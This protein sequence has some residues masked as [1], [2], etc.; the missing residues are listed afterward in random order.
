MPYFEVS[1]VSQK[2]GKPIKPKIVEAMDDARA[3]V[4][5][6]ASGM[7]V[8]SI[9]RLPDDEP[10]DKQVAYA[11][12]LGI[13]IPAGANRKEVSDLISN[14]IDCDEL[15]D[16]ALLAY[17]DKLNILYTKFT[18]EKQLYGRIWHA[19]PSDSVAAWFTYC[20]YR[21]LLPKRITPVATSHEH[22]T[23]QTI[24]EKAIQ[25]PTVFE[26]INRYGGENLAFFG[27][28]TS[29]QGSLQKGG[30]N[31][32][33][34]YKAVSELIRTELSLGI[35]QAKTEHQTTSILT[36]NRTVRVSKSD[37]KPVGKSGCMV[38]VA[39]FGTVTSSVIA[40]TTSIVIAIFG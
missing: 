34:A 7:S 22:P 26:S 8:L 12:E 29:R 1:G 25:A 2:T 4:E 39:I 31:R 14:A 36:P 24:A 28:R 23:I 27:E 33:K 6:E 18:G 15:A 16:P 21:D 40:F 32:T 19:I 37:G 38:M 9:T 17:A 35:P 10:T 20:L 13:K 11:K 3:R 5:A 30:S